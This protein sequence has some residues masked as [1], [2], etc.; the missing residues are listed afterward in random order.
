MPTLLAAHFFQPP[1]KLFLMHL[2]RTAC[3]LILVAGSLLGQG[4]DWIR[5]NYERHDFRIPMRDG[6]HLFTEV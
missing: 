4:A 1:R 5:A 3:V 6:V 2:R